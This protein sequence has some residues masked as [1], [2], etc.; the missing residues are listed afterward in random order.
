MWEWKLN[1]IFQAASNITHTFKGEKGNRSNDL[2]KIP[3][4]REHQ[5]LWSSLK[6]SFSVKF[7]LSR[8]SP[9]WNE[10]VRK[11]Y[12][13]TLEHNFAHHRK[14]YT[15]KFLK[16]WNTFQYIA[17]FE[18]HD[19]RLWRRCRIF[20]SFIFLYF[21]VKLKFRRIK[22]RVSN[23]AKYKIG[24][25]YEITVPSKF[26][27]FCI[28]T[29]EWACKTFITSDNMWVRKKKKLRSQGV[30]KSHRKNWYCSLISSSLADLFYSNSRIKRDIVSPTQF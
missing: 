19:F 14:N 23:V 11:N 22:D 10:T 26:Y 21:I 25:I 12:Y 8:I 4:F 6:H 16:N 2:E 28:F 9:N 5:K 27:V 24:N 7:I 18:K 30:I 17:R 15:R 3:T 20:S 1:F 13:N 29:F